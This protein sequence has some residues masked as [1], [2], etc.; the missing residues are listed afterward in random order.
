MNCSVCIRPLTGICYVF[1]VGLSRVKLLGISYMSLFE[2][3]M[4]V[5]LLGKRLRIVGAVFFFSQK[6]K[7][8]R[9][10]PESK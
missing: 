3:H 6:E 10:L 1:C 9:K 8:K 2:G 7:K 4:F 5:S